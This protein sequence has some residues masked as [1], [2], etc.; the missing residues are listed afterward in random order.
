MREGWLPEYKQASK[1]S[2]QGLNTN[3]DGV[4]LLSGVNGELQQLEPATP[5]STTSA[6]CCDANAW[7]R[8]AAA[9]HCTHVADAPAPACCEGT[10]SQP[11]LSEFPS[12]L[13][14]VHVVPKLPVQTAFCCTACKGGRKDLLRSVSIEYGAIPTAYT[15]TCVSQPFAVSACGLQ[16]PC[17]MAAIHGARGSLVGDAP[18]LRLSPPE[19]SGP[20]AFFWLPPSFFGLIL[21]RQSF[22]SSRQQSTMACSGS[23]IVLGADGSR[24]EGH[25]I[26][27]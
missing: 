15:S 20:H 21:H 9:M 24:N 22:E 12:S 10:L 3:Y 14:S 23:Q 2:S 13:T 4:A 8:P 16:Q 18:W 19:E 11:V 25:H 5:T 17:A 1:L 27:S 7:Q 6:S 26:V